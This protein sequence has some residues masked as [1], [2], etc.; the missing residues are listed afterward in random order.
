SD[1]GTKA[2][3]QDELLKITRIPINVLLE[4]ELEAASVAQKMSWAAQRE[5]TKVEDGAYCLMGIFGV[6]MPL[7]Y[8]EGERAFIRLQEEIMRV[9]DDHSLFAWRSTDDR[10]GLLAT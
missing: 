7:L 2:T 5:T 4:N 9:S 10:G 8:G 1:L 3:L 6:N